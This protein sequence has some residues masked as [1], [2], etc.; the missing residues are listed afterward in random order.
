MQNSW[1]VFSN[2]GHHGGDPFIS[3]AESRSPFS[4]ISERWLGLSSLIFDSAPY[5]SDQVYVHGNLGTGLA[6]ASLSHMTDGLF[7]CLM[8]RSNSDPAANC[9]KSDWLQESNHR[10]WYC[11]HQFFSVFD[12]GKGNVRETQASHIGKAGT[13]SFILERVTPLM[14]RNRWSGFQH[15]P[16][17]PVFVLAAA[18]VPLLNNLS[19]KLLAIPIEDTTAKIMKGREESVQSYCRVEHIEEHNMPHLTKKT[20]GSFRQVVEP[21]TGINF[22]AGLVS[23]ESGSGNT[24]LISQ[25]LVGVG[26][27]STTIAKV[28][29]IKVYAFGLYVQLDCL[30][31]KL[32]QKYFNVPPEELKNR[33]EF[34]EDLLRQDMW[35][36]VRLVVHLKGL[37]LGMVQTFPR[38]C[39]LMK[40]W[41]LPL[42]ALLE[43]I[44]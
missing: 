30:C 16:P 1:L 36:T 32:Q 11:F 7:L 24:S 27:R 41:L 39:E 43:K 23:T 13:L 28:K 20:N 10:K 17:F 38:K 14:L 42:Q 2:L 26:S 34:F 18:F 37:K 21:R 33:P 8:K 31:N 4:Y 19:S 22:P 9:R 40:R 3:A 29:S 12:F 15:Y 5:P 44:M 6:R 35:M 25:V